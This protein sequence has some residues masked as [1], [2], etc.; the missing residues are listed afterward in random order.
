MIIGRS[1]ILSAGLVGLLAFSSCDNGRDTLLANL[2]STRPEERALAVKKL[3]DKAKPE[4]L[5][6]FTSAAKDPASIVRAEAAHALGKS[7]DERV[8]DIL[9]DMLGDDSDDVQ[10]NA[11]M[12]LAEIKTEKAK[13]YLTSQYSRRGRNTRIAIVQ[14]LKAANVPG[15]MAGVVSNEAKS[16]W[17]RNLQALTTGTLPEKVAA[18]EELGKSG[19]AEAVTRLIGLIKDSQ[20]MLASAAVRGLGYAGDRRAVGPISEL[21]SENYPELREAACNALMRLHDPAAL[22]KLLDAALEK[23]ATSSSATAAILELPRQPETDKALCAIILD[24]S[25]NDALAAGRELR[26]RGGCPAEVFTERWSKQGGQAAVLQAAIALG[27]LAKDWLPK[28]LP[29]LQSNDASVKLLAIQ[30]VGA[31]G[32]ASAVPALQKVYD[33]EVKNV[34]A[35]RS[36][37]ITDALPEQYAPGFDGNS[38]EPTPTT[39][40]GKPDAKA[41]YN[42]LFR[43]VAEL[44][45][46]KSASKR[47]TEVRPPTEVI[48]DVSDEQVTVFAATLTALGQLNAPGALELLKARAKDASIP[49][50]QAAL[51]GLTSL[52]AEGIEVARSGLFDAD[53]DVQAAVARALARAGEPG[54][55]AVAKSVAEYAGEKLTMLEALAD[56]GASPSS[57]G[58]LITVLNGGGAEAA[59]AARLLGELKSKEAVEPLIKYLQDPASVARREALIALGKIGDEKAAEVIARDLYHD[60]PDVR[61]AAVEALSSVGT[62][63]QAEPLDALKGDYYRRVRE[64]AETALA[65]VSGSTPTAT[66]EGHK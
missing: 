50:R 47:P 32:D 55:S 31:I 17:D 6:L 21:L 13:A 30:S 15:A 10:A 62:P 27:P 20:V 45:K 40:D 56:Y 26:N 42:D 38:N 11:A 64:A 53:R 3:A 12:A 49:V 41:R 44:N 2:Q 36:D 28:I 34:D 61:A 37:W 46:A 33:A 43:R 19:R 9:G 65:H 48:D 60:S 14:A 1:V 29:L 5:V 52:G 39:E 25:Q 18:A 59:I 24:G 58:S 22:P 23:S 66:G 54:Q 35:L 63:A 57:A 7:Q 4:D 8:V 51:V 16:I